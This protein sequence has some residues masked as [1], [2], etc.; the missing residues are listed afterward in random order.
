MIK[1]GDR[2]TKVTELQ[3]NLARV[4]F[5]PGTIDGIFG[6][7]TDKA[8]RAFQKANGLTV[9]GIAGPATIRKL[10]KPATNTSLAPNFNE[11]EFACKGTSLVYV[12]SELVE[13]LQQLRN[14]LGGRPITIT[15]G[16][17]TPE[18]N[19]RVGGATNSLHMMGLAADIVVSGVS[20][21]K[22]AQAAE[23]IG[24]GGIGIYAKQGFTHVDIG[25][26]RKWNG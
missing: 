23:K 9:D 12:V 20:P 16:Y 26:K 11:R 6:P 24:F 8:L 18:H 5:N 1:K 4:G 21:A 14:E 15:S 2:G 13:K 3:R 19:R 17:R 25:P 10:A 7:A 22:V